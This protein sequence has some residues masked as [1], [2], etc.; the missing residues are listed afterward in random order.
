MYFQMAQLNG[1][2]LEEFWISDKHFP[3]GGV[4]ELWLGPEP[5]KNWKV[6]E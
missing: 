3:D 5:N 4:L 1:V 6:I 2:L